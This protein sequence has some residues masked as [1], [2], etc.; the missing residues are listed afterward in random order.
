MD[1]SGEIMSRIQTSVMEALSRGRKREKE[2]QKHLRLIYKTCALIVHAD[3][4]FSSKEFLRV[5]T[6]LRKKNISDEERQSFLSSIENGVTEED[7]RKEIEENNFTVEEL[8]KTIELCME[9]AGLDGINEQEMAVIERLR[10]I[11]LCR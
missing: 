3:G 5:N 1:K 2:K 8:E 6:F 7:I 10:N 11:L 4:N 9:L